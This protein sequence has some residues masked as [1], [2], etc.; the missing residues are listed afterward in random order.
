MS[1]CTAPN[2]WLRRPQ[3]ALQRTLLLSLILG[4][5]VISSGPGTA[6]EWRQ[7]GQAATPAQPGRADGGAP[8]SGTTSGSSAQAISVGTVEASPQS[9]SQDLA[10]AERHRRLL[11]VLILRSGSWNISPF[12]K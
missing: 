4:A 6:D 9:D 12:P 5:A 2:N 8:L 10:A 11:L 7:S 1:F 3:M